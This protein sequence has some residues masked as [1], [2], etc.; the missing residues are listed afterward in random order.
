[1]RFFFIFLL[2]SLSTS[3]SAGE[4]R[5]RS[6]QHEGFVRLVLT[7]APNQ[8]WKMR[9][10]KSSV[11]LI[12]EN[13][14]D[15][16]DVSD[17]FTRVDRRFISRVFADETSLK[18]GL[19]CDCIANAFQEGENLLVL[20]ISLVSE[21]EKELAN[22]TLI[23]KN[24]TPVFNFGVFLNKKHQLEELFK[25]PSTLPLKSSDWNVRTEIHGKWAGSP[26]DHLMDGQFNSVSEARTELMQEIAGATTRGLL[27]PS[28]FD[29]PKQPDK[30]N[31][32]KSMKESGSS[33]FDYM[34]PN[35]SNNKDLKLKISSAMDIE[36]NN[37]N[38][39]RLTDAP[40]NDCLDASYVAINDWGG[41]EGF[42][43]N[44]AILHRQ[45][46]GEFDDLN[47]KALEDIAK[48]YLHFGFGAEAQLV[49][50]LGELD[51]KKSFILAALAE[52]IDSGQLEDQNA[53]GDLAGCDNDFALWG[54]LSITDIN[55]SDLLN[56][57]ASLLAL[58]GLPMHLRVIVAPQLSHQ[59]LKYGDEEAA[60]TALRILERG[61]NPLSSFGNLA[62]A[63]VEILQG[64]L[65]GAQGRLADIAFSNSQASAGALVQ[66]INS[67]VS[68][69]SDM[70]DDA[71]SLIEA[72]AAEFDSEPIGTDLKRS[73]ILSLAKS[74]YF[75]EAFTEMH[76]LIASTMDKDFRKL[77][78]ELF[79]MLSINGSDAEFLYHTFTVGLEFDNLFDDS[80]AL[81]IANRLSSLGFYEQAELIINTLDESIFTSENF[82]L[83]AGISLGLGL[84]EVAL[85]DIFGVS[86]KVATELRAKAHRNS[87]DFTKAYEYYQDIGDESNT[88]LTGWLSDE[89]ISLL[90]GSTTIWGP[91][92]NIAQEPIMLPPVHDGVLDYSKKSISESKNARSALREIIDLDSYQFS[93]Q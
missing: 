91:V 53:L 11:N 65:I 71:I 25:Y 68:D 84:P 31:L 69:G 21:E 38:S 2:L 85:E 45:L 44:H 36:S 16:F 30:I 76:D 81:G 8:K 82:E 1:M 60:A 39:V 49:L 15:G 52:L 18:I 6:G 29:L 54:I 78:S 61:P 32:Y 4:I 73:H 79:N 12:L 47:Y 72:Y 24:E 27:S 67:Q 43:F 55:S 66:L 41:K 13:H 63:N 75:I 22:N 58:S 86:S 34:S 33:L 56:V 35:P 19:S 48:L 87:G 23:T 64:D 93:N 59:L 90:D 88:E 92:V 28:V 51:S 17:V 80:T 89:W 42:A 37:L 70:R 74:G 57:D 50:Q 20:D 62:K 77:W 3:V 9:T 10:N 26:M 5:V 40:E 14:Q 7:T 46:F 83:K